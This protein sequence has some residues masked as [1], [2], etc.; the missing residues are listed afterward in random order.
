MTLDPRPDEPSAPA[1]PS[2]PPAAW[3][4][5]L[6]ALGASVI[7]LGAALFLLAVVSPSMMSRSYSLVAAGA[8]ALGGAVLGVAWFGFLLEG[9]AGFAVIGGSLALPAAVIVGVAL[10][11]GDGPVAMAT[12][13]KVKGMVALAAMA[14]CA[15]AHAFA[16]GERALV[17][18]RVARTAAVITVIG[19]GGELFA[20][21]KNLELPRAI[22]YLLAT[23]GFGGLAV[24]G[25]ALAIGLPRVREASAG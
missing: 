2:T 4:R 25:L 9:R 5:A 6:G 10:P 20:I 7:A 13:I 22:G 11:T 17:Q 21:G 1:T 19:L 23:L 16:L 12:M 24:M 18:L 15:L 14:L 3:P 8:L